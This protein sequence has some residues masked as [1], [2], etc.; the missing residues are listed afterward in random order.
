VGYGDGEMYLSS[1]AAALA[2]FTDMITY[3]EDGDFAELRR[4]GVDIQDES[5]RIAKRPV[6]K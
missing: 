6:L 5:G 4:S 2:P 3:L 1:D